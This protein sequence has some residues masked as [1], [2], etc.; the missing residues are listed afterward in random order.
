MKA[1]AIESFKEDYLKR[2]NNL[3]QRRFNG[4]KKNL[5][6][7]ENLNELEQIKKLISDIEKD[8]T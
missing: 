6:N 1:L 7:I 3:A 2:E 8:F 4:I 5:K